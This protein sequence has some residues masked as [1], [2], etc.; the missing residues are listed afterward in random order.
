MKESR[1]TKSLMWNSKVIQT[2]HQVSTKEGEHDEDSREENG[3]EHSGKNTD[4][5]R[6]DEGRTQDICTD[7]VN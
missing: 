1:V 7:R 2:F 5:P 4:A 3:L 6:K